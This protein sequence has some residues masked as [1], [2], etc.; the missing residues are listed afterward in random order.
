VMSKIDSAIG[1][2]ETDQLPQN[3]IIRIG[4]SDDD[5]AQKQIK[6][7]SLQKYTR[8]AHQ[9]RIVV[10]YILTT[11]PLYRGTVDQYGN[12]HVWGSM[13][14]CGF[15]IDDV[16]AICVKQDGVYQIL[17]NPFVCAKSFKDDF[18][19]MIEVAAHECAHLDGEGHGESFVNTFQKILKNLRATVKADSRLRGHGINRLENFV[20]DNIKVSL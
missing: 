20:D 19:Y 12:V 17:V 18:I 4:A 6:R 8:L 9:W 5:A 3:W 11:D 13:I 7:L 10:N 2:I 14:K 15:V 1:S 16:E